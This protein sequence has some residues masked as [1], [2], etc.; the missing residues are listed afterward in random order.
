MFSRGIASYPLK[1]SADI[2]GVFLHS[3]ERIYLPTGWN[4]KG[5]WFQCSF[6]Y[7]IRTECYGVESKA[8]FELWRRCVMLVREHISIIESSVR[9]C[10]SCQFTNFVR[11]K[12]RSFIR[13]AWLNVISLT[14]HSWQCEYSLLFWQWLVCVLQCSPLFVP[15]NSCLKFD[16]CVSGLTSRCNDVWCSSVWPW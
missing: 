1:Y 10:C 9:H 4:T 12:V 14:R 16:S 11:K 7:Y 8:A 6:S 13:K 3:I 2:L 5:H 15:Q